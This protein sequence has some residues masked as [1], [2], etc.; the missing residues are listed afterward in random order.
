[1]NIFKKYFHYR[2]LGKYKAQLKFAAA[3][4]QR[5]ENSF[6]INRSVNAAQKTLL[7]YKDK[8]HLNDT[9]NQY[10]NVNINTISYKPHE[11]E[12]LEAMAKMHS[13]KDGWKVADDMLDFRKEIEI[14]WYA[15]GFLI[16]EK[17]Y[18]TW[19]LLII[20]IVLIVMVFLMFSWKLI[21]GIISF[22]FGC[23]L[24]ESDVIHGEIDK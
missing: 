22:L 5:K 1:M 16:N 3:P 24:Y 12:F 10:H 2:K 15:N 11:E 21:V 6:A 7:V 19:L 4:L 20:T 9:W 8:Q 14:P 23:F 18:I 13:A 17:Y